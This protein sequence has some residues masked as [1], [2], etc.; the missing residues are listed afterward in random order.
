MVLNI[1]CQVIAA[2]SIIAVAIPF[3]L[4]HSQVVKYPT[5]SAFF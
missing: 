3:V 5:G 1:I 2:L 4:N